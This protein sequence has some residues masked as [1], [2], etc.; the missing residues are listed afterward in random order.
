M[1]CERVSGGPGAGPGRGRSGVAD[2]PGRLWRVLGDD[3]RAG[4]A[5][6]AG[7]GR[8]TVLRLAPVPA[9][10]DDGEILEVD[11]VRHAIRFHTTFPFGLVGNNRIECSPIDAGSCMLRYG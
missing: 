8:P 10:A 11:G 5:G 3:S 1:A 9:V 7:G 4:R 2:A 6:R